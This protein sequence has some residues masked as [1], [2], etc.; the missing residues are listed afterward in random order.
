[1]Y[2]QAASGRIVSLLSLVNQIHVMITVMF[3]YQ[4]KEIEFL[5]FED[6][7]F[8]STKAIFTEKNSAGFQRCLLY[9]VIPLSLVSW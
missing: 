5:T 7:C 3:C 8:Y 2:G 9:I 6:V 1:M 4:P